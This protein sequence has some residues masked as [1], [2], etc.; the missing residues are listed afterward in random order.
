MLKL[1]DQIGEIMMRRTSIFKNILLTT[2]VLSLLAGAPAVA[3]T[4]FINATGEGTQASGVLSLLLE[5]EGQTIIYYVLGQTAGAVDN[6]AYSPEEQAMLPGIGDQTYVLSN[7]SLFPIWVGY[8]VIDGIDTP[9]VG[10]YGIHQIL[11]NANG[12]RAY[13]LGVVNE[14][15][16][17]AGWIAN[18]LN[19]DAPLAVLWGSDQH[20]T[21]VL[22]D[23]DHTSEAYSIALAAPI[24]VGQ[25]T[26]S[27][28]RN[29]MKWQVDGVD[30]ITTVLPPLPGDNQASARA[31]SL[32]G[33][34]I[35]GVSDNSDT[36]FR[37]VRWD[38]DD[39]VHW[40]GTLGGTYDVARSVN[41]DGSIIVGTS[42]NLAFRWT[43]AT[44]MKDLNELLRD[45]GVNMDGITLEDAVGISYDGY[46]IAANASD[47]A[48]Y[49]YYDD[50]MDR[51]P[52]ITTLS[53]VQSSI[54]ELANQQKV[55]LAEEH[56]TA[57]VLLGNNA[58]VTSDS[59]TYMGGMFGSALGYMGGQ[60]SKE[61]SSVRG[62]ISFGHQDY[63]AVDQDNSLTVALAGRHIFARADALR[64][65]VEMGGWVTPD[66][67]LTL[68]RHYANGASSATGRGTTEAYSWA[69][70]AQAGLI[71][72][73]AEKT[74]LRGFGELGQQV[75]NYDGYSEQPGAG[76]PFP[77]TVDDGQL[78]M[79]VA[80]FGGVVSQ[81]VLG[82]SVPVTAS[83]SG[84]LAHAFDVDSDLR[85]SVAGI[86]STQAASTHA[87]WGEFGLQLGAQLNEQWTGTAGVI[88][89]KGNNEMDTKL[90]GTV[91]LSY[92][93]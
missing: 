25:E 43:Q 47:Q 74:Q 3:A 83:V 4:G 91:G 1:E 32:E 12:G 81:Q 80:R 2:S 87:T 51:A 20:I 42:N 92:K 39:S 71:W 93:F 52:A 86:G 82:G 78:R 34:T 10:A 62:G 63:E 58:A 64:P 31:I 24:V 72:Q 17:V 66:Q 85:V 56:T 19:D 29:A 60:Y 65:Y 14:S 16:V 54:N 53:S 67:D 48:Y 11:E 33:N 45:A 79:K 88:A 28:I 37:A 70:Y 61:D 75:L 68:S 8:T 23:P 6:F 30:I 69:G 36:N 90:H 89:T 40:L 76:N 41:M 49:V 77:A 38:S 55:Q 84:A 35:V 18:Y 22:G 9:Y 13:A 26:V 50:E 21:H 44:G 27:G 57:N 73:A 7:S 46:V 5:E 15:L 59:Y